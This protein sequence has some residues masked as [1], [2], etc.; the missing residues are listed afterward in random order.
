MDGELVAYVRRLVRCAETVV[1]DGSPSAV[2]AINAAAL[3]D[4]ID[5]GLRHLPPAADLVTEMGKVGGVL[6]GLRLASHERVVIADDDVRYDE[7]LLETS[8]RRSRPPTSSVRRTISIR[9]RGMRAGTPDACSST[10]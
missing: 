2:F 1:V 5:A 7:A 10:A 6:T 3:A 9:C 8:T 4:A